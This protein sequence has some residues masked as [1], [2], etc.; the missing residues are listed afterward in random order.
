V[1][2]AADSGVDVLA[3]AGSSVE[4]A[5]ATVDILPVPAGKIPL[6]IRTARPLLQALLEKNVLTGSDDELDVDLAQVVDLL[7]DHGDAFFEAL[8]I[9]TAVPSATLQAAGL[10]EVVRL[11]QT[12]LRVNRDFF[13][14]SVAPLLAGMAQ[15]LPGA[16]PTPSSS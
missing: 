10:D 14:K 8:A 3:P 2:L 12:T 16:G 7:G 13:T 6:L 1:I 5:G 9:A 4:F 11:A 15:R